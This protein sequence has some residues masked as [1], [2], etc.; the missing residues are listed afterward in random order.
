ML[1]S[2]R[3]RALE[4]LSEAEEI[5]RVKADRRIGMGGYG[6]VW[7]LQGDDD[8]VLKI[9]SDPFEVDAVAQITKQR[10]KGN[11]LPAFPI[12][13][14]FHRE[15]DDISE[16]GFILRERVECPCLLPWEKVESFQ[17]VA[18]GGKHYMAKRRYAYRHFPYIAHS[19][20]KLRRS[21]LRVQ[22]IRTANVGHT[23]KSN[24]YRN[25][26]DLV[27]FDFQA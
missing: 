10:A 19:L 3:Q 22:D 11:K 23:L 8:R 21:G 9:T 12:Y 17:Y 7:E 16:W 1:N 14:G 25:A 24:Q 20:S 2:W 6:M 26:G 4:Y 5:F 18:D 15:V 13:Y 27:I